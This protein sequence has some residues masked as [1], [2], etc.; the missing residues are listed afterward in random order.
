MTS[1][2]HSQL[3]IASKIYPHSKTSSIKDFANDIPDATA[4]YG[5]I[6][7]DLLG[8]GIDRMLPRKVNSNESNL[9]AWKVNPKIIPDG[10]RKLLGSNAF[11]QCHQ[12]FPLLDIHGNIAA[13]LYSLGCNHEV[14][15][16]ILKCNRA[17]RKVILTEYPLDCHPY[18][19]GTIG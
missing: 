1:K 2:V 19:L 18:C 5:P 17:N 14:H 4:D 3:K 8:K 11:R 13:L 12:A 15:H 9:R 16:K 6:C 10:L 7:I